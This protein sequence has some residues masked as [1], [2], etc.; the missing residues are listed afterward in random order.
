MCG[1]KLDANLG[2][3]VFVTGKSDLDLIGTRCVCGHTEELVLSIWICLVVVCPNASHQSARDTEAPA[4][5]KHAEQRRCAFITRNENHRINFMVV[6][7]HSL[8]TVPASNITHLSSAL[9]I[10]A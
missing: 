5:I 2:S 6:P 10:G 3:F 7:S 9:T 1:G 4:M 8:I